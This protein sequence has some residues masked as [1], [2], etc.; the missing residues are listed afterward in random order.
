MYGLVSLF[1]QF[2]FT[3]VTPTLPFT[4]LTFSFQFLEPSIHRPAISDIIH[5]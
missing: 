1:F 2:C 4:T 3:H 5:G